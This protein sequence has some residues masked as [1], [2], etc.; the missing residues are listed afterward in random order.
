MFESREIEELIT[1]RKEIHANP[2]LSGDE[3]ET[4]KKAIAFL[5][6]CSPSK[7]ISSVGGHG[8]VAVYDSGNK[9]STLLIRGDMD[10]L[11]IKEVNTF[12]HRSKTD[13]VSHKCGHDGHTTI[14]L[15]LAK[16]LSK[17]PPKKGKALLLFQPAEEIGA[18][19]AAVLSDKKF[20]SLKPDW[21]FGL[22]NLPGYPLHEVVI[23]K[24][25]FTASVVSLVIDL[26]GKTAH[27]AEPEHGIN[28]SLAISELLLQASIWS[29]NSPKR[30]D[31]AVVTPVYVNLG[32][33]AYGTS[34]GKAKLGFTIRTWTEEEIEKLKVKIENFLNN[35]AEKHRLKLSYSYI[36]EFKA[37]ENQ[38]EAVAQIK[39]VAE[40]LKLK[41]TEPQMPFKWGEDFGLFTQQYKGAFFGIGAGEDCPAL[42]NPDYDFPDELL[43]TGSNM[44]YELCKNYL[45]C[46]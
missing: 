29:N 37:C 32:A 17:N 46:P 31:F 15:G 25:S 9:G 40:N 14:L 10:A 38:H 30:K 43:P 34:A 1:F 19:A 18:G 20:T 8:V 22:H 44:F 3:K 26:Y 41:V 28:P 6:D 24:D 21:V 11:P 35:L 45:A 39:K 7:I 4:A 2:E 13:G 23:R 5:E 36:E 33:E 42:H 27:A 12:K 16:L